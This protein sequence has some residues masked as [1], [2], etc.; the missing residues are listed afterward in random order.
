MVEECC[1]KSIFPQVAGSLP[2]QGGGVCEGWK[3]PWGWGRK[4]TASVKVSCVQGVLCRL[5]WHSLFSV[6]LFLSS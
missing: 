1:G 2:I 4:N 5:A 6:P 3:Q